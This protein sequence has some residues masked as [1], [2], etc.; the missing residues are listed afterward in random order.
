[1]ANAT[2]DPSTLPVPAR[3]TVA[4]C[5]DLDTSFVDSV[6]DGLRKTLKIALI[7][8]GVA[9]FLIIAI[10]CLAERIRYKAI[11]EGIEKSKEIAFNQPLPEKDSAHN[12]HLAPTTSTFMAFL[13]YQQQPLAFSLW[14]KVLDRTPKFRSSPT[15]R[16]K[17]FWF[18]SYITHP[19]ALILLLCKLTLLQASLY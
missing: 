11:L 10:S 9:L 13:A 7:L 17:A 16:T 18:M 5:A 6:G 19:P 12:R 3:Q 15:L 14:Q 4:F 2:L 8:L 1:M